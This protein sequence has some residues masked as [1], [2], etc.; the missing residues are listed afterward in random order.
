MRS[1]EI[2]ALDGAPCV[3]HFR[4]GHE[5][6]F[7]QREDD[8]AG[9]AARRHLERARHVFGDALGAVDLR[10]PLRHLAVHAAV[11]DFLE[12]FAVHEVG[13]DLADEQDHR[14]GILVRGVHA[15]GG[16]GRP[17]AARDEADA[18]LARQ[19]AVGLGHERGAAFLAV[20]DEADVRVVQR[21]QH[22]EIAFA[23]HA[24]GGVHAVDL[25][26]ID[27]DLAAAAGGV[28]HGEVILITMES[29][30]SMQVAR[31]WLLK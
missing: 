29:G 21:V 17:G 19:L 18:G 8:G 1:C 26:R 12:R 24:E 16:V 31:H 9:T 30:H 20:D 5:H 23:G 22:V 27:Q 11:V 10:D 15:D 13:A 28:R 14:R 25:E 2:C 6:V 3:R 4:A 7:R